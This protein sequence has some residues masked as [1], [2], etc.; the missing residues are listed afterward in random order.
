[1]PLVQVALLDPAKAARHHAGRAAAWILGL[2]P[3]KLPR[4]HP[5]CVALHALTSALPTQW[6]PAA[7]ELGALVATGVAPSYQASADPSIAKAFWDAL[8]PPSPRPD[9]WSPFRFDLLTHMSNDDRAWVQTLVISR[10]G[11]AEPYA[12]AAAVRLLGAAADPHLA[13]AERLHAAN[14]TFVAAIAAARSR[15]LRA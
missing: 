12:P 15:I 7:H 14:A 6:Q 2:D 10:L 5:L 8:V 9:G 3:D 13:A 4:Q 11:T 1:M